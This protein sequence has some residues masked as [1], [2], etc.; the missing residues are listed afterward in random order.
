VGESRLSDGPGEGP[1]SKGDHRADS[2][3]EKEGQEHAPIHC[4][5]PKNGISWSSPLKATPVPMPEAAL[6]RL[7]SVLSMPERGVTV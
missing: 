2:D 7:R 6:C 5:L 4:L 3:V 1:D